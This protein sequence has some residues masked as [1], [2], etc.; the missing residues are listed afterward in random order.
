[1]SNYVTNKQIMDE[2]FCNDCGIH[3]F[4]I[5]IDKVKFSPEFIVCIMLMFVSIIFYWLIKLNNI[6]ICN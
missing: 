1:M 5:P 3:I 4:V 2:Y 6:K